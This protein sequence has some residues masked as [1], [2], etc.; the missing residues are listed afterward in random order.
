MTFSDFT[1]AV[2]AVVLGAAVALAILHVE[3]GVPF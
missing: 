3:F 2:G 1:Y